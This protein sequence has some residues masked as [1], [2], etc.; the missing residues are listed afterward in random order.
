MSDPENKTQALSRVETSV[1]GLVLHNLEDMTTVAQV[2]LQSGLAPE[3]FDT[4]EKIFVGLQTG[5]EIGLKP[6]QALNSIVVIHGKPTL[7]GDAALALVKRSGLLISFSEKVTGEG[8]GMI[9][10]VKSVR[11]LGG[12]TVDVVEDV[13]EST[14]SVAD[15]KTAG[16]WNKKGP[17][18][19]HPKRMLK[20]KARAFNLRDNFPDVL[21]G[22][23]LTEEMYGEEPL[24]A[25]ET[26]VKPRGERR[27]AVPSKAVDTTRAPVK[28]PEPRQE[29]EE[30]TNADY[31]ECWL[32]HPIDDADCKLQ[33]CP[34]LDECRKY[35]LDEP[36]T[37]LVTFLCKECGQ[38]V[39]KEEGEGVPCEC[40]KGIL[41]KFPEQ[42]TEP[43]LNGVPLVYETPMAEEEKKPEDKNSLYA[44]VTGL[45]ADQNGADFLEFACYV[46]LLDETEVSPGKLT[47]EQLKQIKAYIETNGVA[48]N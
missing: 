11:R 39:Q 37:V 28:E 1:C 30:M 48:I 6:M 4:K 3:S 13:V 35:R 43:A 25:P 2:I 46:L 26:D 27:M 32:V 7:W 47:V 10:V 40:G 34:N 14:F 16:L 33:P 36:K 38:T 8:D 20:Y 29:L 23:H 41:V 45:Y 5:A 18:Q 17:W 31:K 12:T 21:F 15:A 9:A 22:M 24:P 44:E 19:T 42:A